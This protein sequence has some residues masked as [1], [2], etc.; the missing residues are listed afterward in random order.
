M[1]A[2]NAKELIEAAT[3]FNDRPSCECDPESGITNCMGCDIGMMATHILS[4]I[5]QDDNEPVTVEWVDAETPLVNRSASPYS[6]NY[7]LRGG[8]R[9]VAS[10]KPGGFDPCV[11]W[12]GSA[13]EF[14]ELGNPTRGDIRAL[15]RGL[16]VPL[17]K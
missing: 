8:V 11:L 14:C 17:N 12:C 6:R 13:N 16:R 2:M 5:R 9:L 15:L 7:L 1:N 10:A 4:T 3:Y